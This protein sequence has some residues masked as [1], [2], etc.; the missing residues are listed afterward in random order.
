MHASAL[1]ICHL[2]NVCEVWSVTLEVPQTSDF[3]CVNDSCNLL[4]SIVVAVFLQSVHLHQVHHSLGEH[5]Y[6]EPCMN[7]SMYIQA[8]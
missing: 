1:S 6:L 2:H 7:L 3:D 4:H 5:C 8:Y